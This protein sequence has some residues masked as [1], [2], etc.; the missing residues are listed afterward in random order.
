MLYFDQDKRE[1]VEAVM[2]KYTNKTY[3]PL[4][5]FA[6]TNANKDAFGSIM[7]AILM[8]IPIVLPDDFNYI[9]YLE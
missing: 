5:S 8:R 9:D 7:K 6:M 2:Q 1:D 4:C 3:L